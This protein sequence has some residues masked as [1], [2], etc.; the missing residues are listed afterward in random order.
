MFNFD[1]LEQSAN[2]K[3]IGVGGGGS[4][5]VNLMIDSA[6]PGVEF[7]VCNTDAQA[8]AISDSQVRIQI[9]TKLTKGLGA[10]ADF[11]IGAKAAEEDRDKLAEAIDGADMVFIT[12]G[13]G[14][15]TGTGAAPVVAEIARELGALTVAV[16]T[17]PFS[18]E[19][20]RR[21][22]VAE[23]GL[24]RLREKVDTLIV[25]PNDRLLQVADPNM[26]MLAAFRMADDVLLFGVQGITDLITVPGQINL[27]FAD[28]K[29][30]M[31]SS[32]SALMGIGEGV[33]EDRAKIAALAA[34]SSPLLEASI[35]GATGLLIN[36]C[37]GND[38]GIFEVNTAAQIISESADPD[39]EIIFGTAI[40][41]ELG[42]KIKITVIATGFDQ[43]RASQT[44]RNGRRGSLIGSSP[45]VAR[46][47]LEEMK[48]TPPPAG[49][50]APARQKEEEEDLDI[51]AFLR[52]RR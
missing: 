37:G 39:A 48:A 27:D 49:A 47:K 38:L 13:M 24:K 46:S 50:T 30:I 10:G 32:G 7:I 8:L 25:I 1:A 35:E 19:G 36:I 17:K 15:G 3:V 26:S 34:I 16:V 22:G 23:E 6:L 2:I 40:N 42:D 28:V 12:A 45:T 52:R 44:S 20:R 31:Q 43:E 18:F 4:N 5:A 41:P 51:P 9:G 29:T 11:E 14:G 33:G 21:S